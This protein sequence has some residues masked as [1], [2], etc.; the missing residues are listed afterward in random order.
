[1]EMA[2]QRHNY[3]HRDVVNG[4]KL[5]TSQ[6]CANY[7]HSK[8]SDDF[9][10]HESLRRCKSASALLRGASASRRRKIDRGTMGMG[11]SRW[12]SADNL[13][14]AADFVYR[15]LSK[16]NVLVNGDEAMDDE[17]DYE[18]L[19]SS[20]AA[21]ESHEDGPDNGEV[22]GDYGDTGNDD[23]LNL[24]TETTNCDS[25]A[26]DGQHEST[27]NSRCSTTTADTPQLNDIAAVNSNGDCC[28][29]IT[30]FSTL[31]RAKSR[32]SFTRSGS[33]VGESCKLSSRSSGEKDVQEV[34]KLER[35]TL[36]DD[37]AKVK[38][39]KSD[40]MLFQCTTLPRAASPAR[41]R[42]SEPH[43][44]HSLRQ[45]IDLS[46]SPRKCLSERVGSGS[47]SN[48]TTVI[49]PANSGCGESTSGTGK[50]NVFMAGG[51]TQNFKINSQNFF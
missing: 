28:F 25:T 37:V 20:S 35:G 36:S 1:M 48:N 8:S 46:D 2:L 49:A 34:T 38:T 11:V 6:T 9:T 18:L 23:N 3:R 43:F 19:E 17:G 42:F 12:Q 24:V 7:P 10:R 29:V 27:E 50:Q 21:S 16:V 40:K 33:A 31:P 32:E 13:T 41:S 15:P 14:V 45:N 26:C 39:Q 4:D 47:G 51:G 22:E 30:K 5:E 44:R